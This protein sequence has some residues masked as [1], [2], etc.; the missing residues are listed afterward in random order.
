MK[1]FTDKNMSQT[2]WPLPSHL[3]CA[4]I[5]KHHQ[6]SKVTTHTFSL[7]GDFV[8][9]LSS[10]KWPARERESSR[11]YVSPLASTDNGYP[12]S[13][14]FS[15][16][17]PATKRAGGIL[18]PLNHYWVTCQR[19][20]R[21][22]FA[23]LFP[24]SWPALGTVRNPVSPKSLPTHLPKTEFCVPWFS[25]NWQMLYG[26]MRALRSVFT[27]WLATDSSKNPVY[28]SLGVGWWGGGGCTVRTCI[29]SNF[30]QLTC[31]RRQWEPYSVAH[32][33]HTG[34]KPVRELRTTQKYGLH[35]LLQLR[36]DSWHLPNKQVVITNEIVFCYQIIGCGTGSNGECA[37]VFL[38]FFFKM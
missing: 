32:S 33:S 31:H 23:C 34:V 1:S 5:Q 2:H 29:P 38:Q 15:T 26:T 10:T 14:L 9:T 24:T 21:E 13:P 7:V 27:N 3:Q 12:A 28:P 22:S 20:Q 16:N 4:T 6:C 35:T 8:S 18:Y 25:T 19:G 36:Q 37:W 17:W 11:N 30:F